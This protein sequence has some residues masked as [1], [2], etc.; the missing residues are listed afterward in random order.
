MGQADGL[1]AT[2]ISVLIS[3]VLK[4][5]RATQMPEGL[6]L[7]RGMGGLT[8]LPDPFFRADAQGRRGYVEWGFVSATSDPK[9]GERRGAVRGNGPWRE[10]GLR[11]VLEKFR[12]AVPPQ[13]IPLSENLLPC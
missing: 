2:T 12:A 8:D 1:F 9:V 13:R 4:V 6:L 5:A 10:R 7:Y 11:G 3:A